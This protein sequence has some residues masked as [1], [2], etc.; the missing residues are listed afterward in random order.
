MSHS[1]IMLIYYNKFDAI[2]AQRPLFQNAHFGVIYPYME[3]WFIPLSSYHA[4]LFT[5]ITSYSIKIK[6]KLLLNFWLE[7]SNKLLNVRSKNTFSF[8]Q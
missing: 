6:N 8:S 7:Y 1:R 4:F 3:N 2:H 5:L